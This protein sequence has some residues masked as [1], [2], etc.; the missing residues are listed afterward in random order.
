VS[1]PTTKDSIEKSLELVYPSFPLRTI[2]M[3]PLHFDFFLSM[4]L[5]PRD[6][7]APSGRLFGSP[8][9]IEG[10]LLPL[11]VFTPLGPLIFFAVSTTFFFHPF[12]CRPVAIFCDGLCVV[13]S[14]DISFGA[15]PS[16]ISVI[17]RQFL[18]ARCSKS[19]CP[20]FRP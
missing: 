10:V 3:G 11:F 14:K 12:L 7:T 1:S 4:H 9:C 19:F 8:L 5:P 18:I 13:R 2:T 6:Q 20:F 15:S 17:T 16:P